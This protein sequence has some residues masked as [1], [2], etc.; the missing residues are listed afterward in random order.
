MRRPLRKKRSWMDFRNEV[1]KKA[2]KKT[3]AAAAAAP[4]NYKRRRGK[5]CPPL[6]LLAF[7]VENLVHVGVDVRARR[8]TRGCVTTHQVEFAVQD[9]ARQPVPGKGH[10]R[11]Q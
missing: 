4:V 3:G 8:A 5:P 7:D 10:V 11:Q 1:G 2:G 9:V 6:G